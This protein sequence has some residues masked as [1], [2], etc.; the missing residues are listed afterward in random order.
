MVERMRPFLGRYPDKKAAG[1]LEIGFMDGF[2]IPGNLEVVPPLSRNLKSALLHSD[3][4][5]TKLHKEVELGRM[6]GPF[7]S[8]PF[9]DLVV[10][11]LG[12]VPKK[13]PNKFRLILHLSFPKGG[14]S[15]MPLARKSVR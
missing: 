15:I 4:V 7:S 9:P 14:R 12:V 1:L 8:A 6:A 3:V 2:R 11:P 5:S 13:E 10:S